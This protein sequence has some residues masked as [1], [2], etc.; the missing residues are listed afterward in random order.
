MT[1]NI[2]YVPLHPKTREYR[3]INNKHSYNNEYDLSL[4]RDLPA[5]FGSV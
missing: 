3:I 2:P 5:L 4:Y 1:C